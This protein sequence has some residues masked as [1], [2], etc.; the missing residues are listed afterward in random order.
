MIPIYKPYM[1]ENITDKLND[2]LYSGQLAYGKIGKEFEEAL[3]LFIGTNKVITTSTY[4]Q[5]LLIAIS[6]LELNFGDEIIASPVSCLASNQ[7]FAVKGLKIKWVDINPN[8][9]MIDPSHLRSIISKNT[10]AIFNNL[11]CGYSGDLNEIYNI[12]KEF[13]IPVVDDCIEAFGTEYSGKKVG[14]TGA[15]ISVFSFQ[16]VRLPNTIDGGALS[17][18][19]ESLYQKGKLIRDYGIDRTRFRTK[20]GEINPNCDIELEGYGATM[21]EINSLI[22]LEQMKNIPQLINIQRQNAEEWRKIFKNDSTVKP[23][24][25][26]SK[27]NPNYWVYG[28]LTDNKDEF[29]QNVRKEGFYSTSVHINNNIY[30]VFKNNVTLKGVNEFMDKYVAIPSGWWFKK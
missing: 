4:N 29:L 6:M 7:P 23:L 8:S 9:G 3:S 26:N 18:N 1:P 27:V 14:N 24:E 21:N 15:D 5:A 11:F 16:T 10:K 28:V 2:I 19:T 12:G 30:S 22:G 25:I 20:N 13:E 17:F